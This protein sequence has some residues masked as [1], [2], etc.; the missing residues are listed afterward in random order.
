MLCCV[1]DAVSAITLWGVA[2]VHHVD[3]VRLQ[4]S[5]HREA[6]VRSSS[7]AIDINYGLIFGVHRDELARIIRP[8]YLRLFTDVVVQ[9]N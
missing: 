1:L 2:V 7:S 4:E 6:W 3:Q 8:H 9:N 5:Q